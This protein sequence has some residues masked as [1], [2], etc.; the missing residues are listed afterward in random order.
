MGYLVLATP[1]IES[2][3]VVAF[4]RRLRELGWI[5]GR[6][7]AIE[8]RWGEGRAER[9]AEIAAEFV[10]IK[11]DIIVTTGTPTVVAAKQATGV[12]PIVT[13]AAGDP[14]DTNLVASLAR[15]GGNVTGLSVQQT[16]TAGKRIELLREV[17][18]G[19][20][21][22]AIL[23]NVGSSNA[24]VDMGEVQAIAGRLGLEVVTSEIRQAE[25]IVPAFEALNGRA[26]ALYVCADPLVLTNRIRINNL[27]QRVGLPTTYAFREFSESGGLMSY[28]AKLPG[29]VPARRRVRRQDSARSKARR[30]PGRAADQIRSRH[31][32][33][34]R[35]GARP[36]HSGIV[37][38]TRR[39]GH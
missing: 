34:H 28:G 3:W 11:V 1:Y 22:L 18:P 2:K 7:V 26:D 16:D 25:D 35:Q 32:S 27:A 29:P 33:D 8:Y 36:D 10:R 4:V 20:H 23:A 12:I 38:A 9:F 24:V 6:T 5:E 39:R 15:P 37:P 21:R 30:H 19:L 13:A 31:Q 14:V 17:I